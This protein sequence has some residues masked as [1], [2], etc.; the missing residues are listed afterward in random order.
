MVA[1]VGRITAGDGY[2]YLADEVT[3]S[4]H[5]YYAGRGEAAGVWAGSGRH[6]LGLRGSVRDRDMEALYGR[7]VDPRTIGSNEVT[8]GRKLWPRVMHEGTPREHVAQ[9]NAAFDVTFSPSKSMSALW[10]ATSEL[11]RG[12]VEAAH[13]VAV[14]AGLAYLE[15]NASHT[16]VGAGGL[17]RAGSSAFVIA[18]FDTAR[19]APR[20]PGSASATHNCTRTAPSSTAFAATTAPGALSTPKRSTDTRTQPA[21]STERRSN[22]S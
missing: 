21:R 17:R 11:V 20:P 16:R 8:L 14:T 12:A 10:A 9:P 15:A 2:K 5:D 4:R 13:D 18:N 3:T 1:S 6:E 22:A 7:F 19:H